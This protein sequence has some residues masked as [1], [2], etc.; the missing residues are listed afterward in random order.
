MQFADVFR[1]VATVLFA[2]A[3]SGPVY[4][5][6]LTVY[7]GMCNASASIALGKDHFVVADDDV[8]VLKIYRRGQADPISEGVGLSDFLGTAAKKQSDLEGAARIGNRIY[9]ISSHG[10]NSS[11]EVQERRRRFFATDVVEG[12]EPAVK[13]AGKPYSKLLDDLLKDT[14]FDKYDFK[15]GAKKAPKTPNAFNIEGLAATDDGKLF[16]GFRNPLSKERKALIIPLENPADLIGDPPLP[17]ADQKVVAKFGEPIELFLQE[18][19]I[20]SIE[21]DGHGGYLIVAG[22][23]DEENT[24]LLYRWSGKQT[25]EVEPNKELTLL[26]K[27]DFAAFNPEAMHLIPGTGEVEILSDDGT[28]ETAGVKCKD[29]DDVSKKLFR[30]MVVKPADLTP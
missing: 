9:W 14:R 12:A 11:G 22:A 13:T 28:V 3:L 2:A 25:G 27:V 21:N 6:S 18:R 26:K 23:I 8:N 4:A 24:S 5:Q 10:T 29:Q 20:R 19:G 30:G 16:I 7:R 17:S 15:N 1:S